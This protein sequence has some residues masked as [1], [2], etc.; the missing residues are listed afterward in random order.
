MVGPIVLPVWLVATLNVLGWPAIML[1]WSWLAIRAPSRWFDHDGWW[2]RARAWERNGR[3]WRWTGVHRWKRWLPDGAACFR[4]GFRKQLS[5]ASRE[6]LERF[7]VETV[8]AELAHL[9]MLAHA[10]LFLLFN[11]PWAAAVM[12][13]FGTLVNLP[14]MVTQRYNRILLDRKLRGAT[15]PPQSGKLPP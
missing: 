4:G 12:L 11:P 5:A 6:Q 3:L 14:C 2:C 7:R 1:G 15:P 8:R 9:V 10:P 13:A